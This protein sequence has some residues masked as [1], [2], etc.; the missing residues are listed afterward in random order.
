[1][2]FN[3]KKNKDTKVFQLFPMNQEIEFKRCDSFV[4]VNIGFE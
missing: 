4:Y 1:M 2:K 3:Q